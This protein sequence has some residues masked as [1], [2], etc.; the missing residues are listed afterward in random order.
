MNNSLVP[1]VQVERRLTTGAIE[2][3]TLWK[4]GDLI[5]EKR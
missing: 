3:K 4:G 5:A 2:K 1:T